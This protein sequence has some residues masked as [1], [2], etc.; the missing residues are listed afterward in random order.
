MILILISKL[1]YTILLFFALAGIV[2]GLF[3]I[4]VINKIRR[5]NNDSRQ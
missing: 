5:M 4:H 1:H 2:D 3:F